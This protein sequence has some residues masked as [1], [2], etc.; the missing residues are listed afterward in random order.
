MCK[1]KSPCYVGGDVVV[2]TTY[3]KGCTSSSSKC[4]YPISTNNLF[5]TGPN[6]PY[7]GI[8]TNEILTTSFQKIDDKINPSNLLSQIIAVLNT[9][10]TLKAA[11]C[12]ALSDCA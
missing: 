7:T 6:L 1:C 9:N 10:P 3:P 2:Y 8:S 4:N 11:L 12:A 5:Y